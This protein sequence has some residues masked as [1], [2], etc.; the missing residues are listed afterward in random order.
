MVACFEQAKTGESKIFATVLALHLG[1]S[2]K[3]TSNFSSISGGE[4][5]ALAASLAEDIGNCDQDA[6]TINWLK[7]CQRILAGDLTIQLQSV[8]PVHSASAIRQPEKSDASS[9][10]SNLQKL[11]S[12]GLITQAEFDQKRSQILEDL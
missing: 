9:R 1:E 5:D 6:W 11:L 10:L 3:A 7:D 4:K 12:D 2:E 8:L